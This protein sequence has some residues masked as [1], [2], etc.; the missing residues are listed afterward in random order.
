P[1]KGNCTTCHPA[2]VRGG[3]FP[4]FSDW[5]FIALGVPRNPAIPA[6]AD[7]AHFDLGLCGPART[8]LAGKEA[9][10][11]LFRTPTLRTVRRTRRS[12]HSGAFSSLR[13]VPRFYAERD[14][15]PEK[16]YPRGADGKVR[17]FDDL[18]ARHHANVN[19]D[20][21]FGRPRGAGASLSEQEIDD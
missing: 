14:T 12:F 1:A 21:P 8:D 3:A 20:P 15:P 19:R 16:F 18:P 9:Y 13:E 6:N 4:V 2:G 11:G 7:P 17:P 5:G 10:C